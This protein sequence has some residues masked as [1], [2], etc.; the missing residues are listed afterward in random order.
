[1]DSIGEGRVV[2]LT[3][4]LDNL[5]NDFPLHPVFVPFIEQ[6]ARYLSGTEQR[7]GSRVVD[8]LLELRTAKDQAASVEI[9]DQDGKRPLSLQE[10]TSARSYQLTRAGFYE[11]RLGNGRSDVIGVNP[12]PRDSDLALIPDDVLGLWRGN[13]SDQPQ[14]ADPSGQPREQEKSESIWWYAMLLVFAAAL[15]ESLLASRYLGTQ[16]EE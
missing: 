15:A 16:R 1:M 7:S 13:T 11:L 8:S 9:I 3:S 10:A 4:G 6:T 2:L 5:T 14:Q 12:D